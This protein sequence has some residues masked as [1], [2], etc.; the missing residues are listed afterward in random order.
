MKKLLLVIKWLLKS[1]PVLLPAA[2]GIIHYYISVSYAIETSHSNKIISFFFKIIGGILVLL[3]IDSNLGIIRNNSLLSLFFTYIKS[4]PLIKRSYVLNAES[5][6]LQVIVG[7]PKLRV[8]NST[9]TLE[10]KLIY[11]QQQ[12]DWLKE[13]L[14][15]E[16]KHLKDIISGVQKQTDT[17]ISEIQGSIGNVDKKF[18]ELSLGSIKIQIFGVLLMVHG[19]IS[20]FYA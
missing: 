20:S 19:A 13:D 8:S 18:S 3:S 9:N 7:N 14:K 10:G 2:F 6:S 15:D 16:A 11:L 17:K 12:I 5:A 4:C 1:W